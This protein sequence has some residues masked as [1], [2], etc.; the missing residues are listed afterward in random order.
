MKILI[1]SFLGVWNLLFCVLCAPVSNIPSVETFDFMR[2]YGY[3]PD[4]GDNSAALFTEDGL[5]TVIKE[6]QK[7]GAL[8]QTGKLDN[9]TLALM[10]QPRCG[11]ADVLRDKSGK[12]SKRFVLGPKGWNKRSITFFIANWS[13]KLSEEIVAKYITLG[14]ETWGRYANLQFKRVNSPEA[15]IIVAFGRGYHGDSYPFDGPGNILA[16]AFFPYEQQSLGGDI[17]FD[18]DENWTEDE[19]P[20]KG[21][22]FF[23]VAIHELG[24]SLGLSH[25][26]VRSSVMFAYY[27][28]SGPQTLDYD[29]ILGM[30]E[31]YI[32][33]RLEHDDQN[34]SSTTSTSW[35]SSTTTS[36]YDDEYYNSS[37]T[38][39][40]TV[41][42]RWFPQ[43]SSTTE[44]TS[45][46]STINYHGDS[47]SV[48]DHK[49]HDPTHH[50]PATQPP[51]RTTVSK[52]NPTRRSDRPNIP[53]ICQGDYDAIAALRSELFVF[54]GEYLWRLRKEYD[55]IP[56]Y[57]IPF[58][59]MFPLLP[60]SV[61]QINA[62]YQR[63]DGQIVLFSGKQYWVF[64]GTTFVEGSPRLLTDLGLPDSMESLDAVQNWGRN[65]KTYFYRGNMFWRY[66]E[67]KKRMDD[68]YPMR[69]DRWRG[70]PSNMDSATT[71]KGITYFFKGRCYWKFDNDWIITTASSPFPTP[72]TWFG[73]PKEEVEHCVPP[74]KGHPWD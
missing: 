11:V 61:K 63:P 3:I 2:K 39:E 62:A 26:P 24:H 46:S 32:K 19:D 74:T 49:T 10:Q 33:R 38:T 17:H 72:Q 21:T 16:H 8:K 6:I 45:W 36:T 58:R 68:E 34:W 40:M 23:Q 41:T 4:D 57:P 73:C 1:I 53:D 18:D 64:D 47:E 50:I 37:S 71:W 66:D 28:G 44:R 35:S 65:G 48:D 56:G 20:S 30:Y 31:L 55:I 14:L 25:S 15:D 13:G 69:M 12:R 27:T 5:D 51:W 29:D 67:N 42:S 43:S 9:D 60:R 54:K 70:V 52:L 7:Y 22:N 59:Q